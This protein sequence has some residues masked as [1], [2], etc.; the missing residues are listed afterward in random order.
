[1]NDLG[2]LPPQAIDL[3][4][5]VIGA[6]LLEKEAL[7]TLLS[8]GLLP[9]HFYNPA[10]QELYSACIQLF[11][12]SE[13]VDMRTVVQRLR[14]DGKIDVVGGA[15]RVA[16]ITSKVSSAA[17]A[18]YHARVIQEKFMLRQLIALASGIIQDSYNEADIFK[19]L[20]KAETNL[21]NINLSRE[22]AGRMVN[23]LE[24]YSLT[25]QH[26]QAKKT[27]NGITGIHTGFVD[28]NKVTSGWQ[29]SDLVIVAARPG[30]GKTSFMLKCAREAAG[31]SHPVLIFS[32]EMNSIQL[33][34]RLIS[35][36]HKIENEKIRSGNLSQ[37]EWARVVNDVPENSFLKPLHASSFFIDDTAAINITEVRAIAKRMKAKHDIQLIIIDYLQLMRGESKGN[38]EQEIASISR[39]LKQIAKELNLPVIALSQLSRGVEQRTDKRPMLSDL[40]ESGAIEQDAD[41]VAFLFRAEYYGIEIDEEG[42]PT[43]GRAEVLIEKH[44]NGGTGSIAIAFEKYYTKF[45]DI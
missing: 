25:V 21:Y 20:E 40:R 26:I 34:E 6:A 41:L 15:Y 10:H 1:M 29:N 39:G 9:Q 14:K 35:G 23:S 17:N 28:L 5:A 13:P 33:M 22:S 37:E 38:R 42:N 7:N 36:E 4:E 3:E 24:L 8:V 18:E 30:M 27:H 45:L 12:N 31:R 11:N 43:A 2:K 32:L 16:E 44:R 19:L